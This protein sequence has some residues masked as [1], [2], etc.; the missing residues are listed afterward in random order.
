[1]LTG[2]LKTVWPFAI[3][4]I[5]GWVLV[6]AVAKVV[7]TALVPGGVIIWASTLVGGM[8]LR[9]VSGQGTAVSFIIVAAT[10][11]AVFLLGWRALLLLKS[12]AAA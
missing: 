9:V 5:V 4:L 7:P 11:L 1:M 6:V 2:L 3:G 12:S 10:V 8:L